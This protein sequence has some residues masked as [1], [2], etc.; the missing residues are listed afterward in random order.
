MNSSG[1]QHFFL[2]TFG[3][4]MNQA[5]AQRIRGMLTSLG[6]AETAAEADADLILYN[7]CCVRE[8]A[9]QR[10]VSRIQ[11]LQ[12]LKRSRPHL[13]IGIAG[14][15]AQAK[16]DRLFDLL[17]HV[18]LVFGPNDIPTLPLLL[19]QAHQQRATGAFAAIGSFDGEHVDGIL[20]ERPF[21]ALV[22]IIR[23]CTNFCSYCIVPHVRGPEVSRPLPELLA[24]IRDLAAKGVVEITLLGQNVNAYGK[25]LGMQEGFATLLE[26]VEQIPGIRWVRFLTSHP[27]DFTRDALL[28]MSRL[29]K[30]CEQFHLPA[31]AGSDRILALMN[32][33]Y[34]RQRYLDLVRDVRELIPG[35]CITTDLICGFPT[36]T[37]SEFEETLS[38]VREARYESAYTYYYSP[39]EGTPAATMPGLLPE[40]ERKARLARL[41][42]VQN[43][44]A[45]EESSRQ[46]GRTFELLV[47]SESSR[48]PG[49]LLGKTRTGRVVDFA[50]TPDLIGRFV[51][52]RIDR[53]RLW[54]M[55]GTLS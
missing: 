52:V 30:L 21:S 37:E 42:E 29:T 15:V 53:A 23:G 36:E 22:N 20:L 13:L 44:I 8:H 17:P 51:T 2:T 28:R 33:G 48:T 24:F 39:R 43:A 38:L 4:Q 10:L 7:T 26:E 50:G 49:H 54:T 3:C 9:E 1:K 45:E 40:E 18:D 41:I 12:S 35:A 11:S 32:R 31:Q 47:E 46:V 14:C 6:Y 27:R 34:T 19:Q 5:D 55:S 16:Q 25:D